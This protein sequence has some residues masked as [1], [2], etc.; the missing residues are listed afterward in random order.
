MILK[1]KK[2]LEAIKQNESLTF[3]ETEWVAYYFPIHC[4]LIGYPELLSANVAVSLAA[5]GQ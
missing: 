3:V 1:K 4:F 2:T 5:E